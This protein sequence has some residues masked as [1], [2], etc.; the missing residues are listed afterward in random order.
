ME[1]II[2]SIVISHRFYLS[3]SVGITVKFN[4][5][6]C[7]FWTKNVPYP[8][9]YPYSIIKFNQIIFMMFNKFFDRNLFKFSTNFKT[10][11]IVQWK[12]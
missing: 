11:L 6:N 4:I 1:S 5:E 2:L 7:P 10:N 12:V 8:Y 3:I 9:P